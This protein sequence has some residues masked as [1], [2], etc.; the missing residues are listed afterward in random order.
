[1]KKCG[2]DL[3]VGKKSEDAN[4]DLVQRQKPQQLLRMRQAILNNSKDIQL[5]RLE[6]YSRRVV[7]VFPS[8]FGSEPEW[9][10][11]IKYCLLPSKTT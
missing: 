4:E 7:S 8:R 10:T 9:S 5:I 3:D 2:S 6:D 11:H 1:M